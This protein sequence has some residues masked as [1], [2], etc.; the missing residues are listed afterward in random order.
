MATLTTQSI[1]V[2]GAQVTASQFPANQVRATQVAQQAGV[3]QRENQARANRSATTVSDDKNRSIAQD[4]RV[5]GAFADQELS[6]NDPH[7]GTT[8][9]Q[10]LNKTA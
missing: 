7:D 5:E 6:E 1:G 9:V 4:G 8:P 10:R 3:Q 2:V